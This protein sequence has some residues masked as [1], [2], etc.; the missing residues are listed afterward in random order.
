[1]NTITE[2]QGEVARVEQRLRAQIREA[3]AALTA[4]AEVGGDPIANLFV[5][6]RRYAEAVD[7]IAQLEA[8]AAMD[9][10]ASVLALLGI[11]V[12][13]DFDEGG[14]CLDGDTGK[15]AAWA[16]DPRTIDPETGH[17]EGTIDVREV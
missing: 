5:A 8:Q 14:V 15:L 17:A 12:H 7:K 2:Q 10:A 6:Q 9:E 16:P 1:M 3:R 13:P 11:A 4:Y